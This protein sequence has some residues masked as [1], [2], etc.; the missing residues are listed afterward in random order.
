[1]DFCLRRMDSDELLVTNHPEEE[2]E[3]VRL[4]ESFP[5]K[6]DE[7]KD[8]LGQSSSDV[9]TSESTNSQED[10]NGDG[11]QIDEARVGNGKRGNF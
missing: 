8:I 5:L 9:R 11:G 2:E 10:D 7:P 4:I 1:M 3:D 6:L